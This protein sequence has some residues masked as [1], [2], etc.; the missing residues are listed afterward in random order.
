MID[1]I[2]PPGGNRRPSHCH[3]ALINPGDRIVASRQRGWSPAT[4]RDSSIFPR[5]GHAP[6]FFYQGPTTVFHTQNRTGE[7]QALV[8]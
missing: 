1:I 8:R 7:C 3:L 2:K 6:L 4:H 5:T